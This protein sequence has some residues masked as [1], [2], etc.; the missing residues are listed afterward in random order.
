MWPK[1]CISALKLLHSAG[2]PGRWHC[3]RD[4]GGR[5]SHC[6]M[7]WGQGVAA[8]AQRMRLPCRSCLFNPR[9][10]RAFP[11][12]RPLAGRAQFWTVNFPLLAPAA[13]PGRRRWGAVLACSATCV[14]SPR[15]KVTAP[16]RMCGVYVL[17]LQE[18]RAGLISLLS[19]L[20]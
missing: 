3:C 9:A 15:P 10:K 4:G 1:S 11:F 13:L 16:Q 8:L 14:R 19:I 6:R 18:K 12:P 5:S 17:H 20:L 2:G 7:Q